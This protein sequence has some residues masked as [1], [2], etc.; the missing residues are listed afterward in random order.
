MSR[1]SEEEKE[2]IKEYAKGISERIDKEDTIS[3]ILNIYW[4]V[5]RKYPGYLSLCSEERHMKEDQDLWSDN[6]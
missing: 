1:L 3:G 4:E 2:S 6:D 5:D